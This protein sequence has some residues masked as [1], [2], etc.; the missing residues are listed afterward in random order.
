M[1]VFA[2][3]G[4]RRRVLKARGLYDVSAGEEE[5]FVWDRSEGS[6]VVWQR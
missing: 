2:G 4:R 5:V 6:A 1:K 3:K